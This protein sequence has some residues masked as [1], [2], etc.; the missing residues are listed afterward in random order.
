MADIAVFGASG[1]I[2][3]RVVDEALARGHRVTALARDRTRLPHEGE[4]LTVAA[5]DVLD[6]GD[7]SSAARGQDVLV[8]AVGGG[9]SRLVE[10]SA[11]TIVEVLR[12]LED[13]PRFIRVG[14]AGSL[15]AA[16]GK[17][18]WDTP[19]LPEDV[20]ATMHA[21][22]DALEFLHGVT[23]V[24]WTDI[25]PPAVVEPGERT[26][27]YRTD[28]HRLVADARGT[29]R[30]SAEDYAVAL[31]DEIESPRHIDERFTVGH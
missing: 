10:P 26:C 12:C 22:G 24:S 30:I 28:T 13:R 11:R 23:D 8:S 29:S 2:G 9:D 5:A 25:S 14:G 1:M 19:G 3:S 4:R 21:H 17:R 27:G 18:V 6:P 31:L 15:E 7:V 16:P 20:L